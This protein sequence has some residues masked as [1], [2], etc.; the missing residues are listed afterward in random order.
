MYMYVLLELVYFLAY[1]HILYVTLLYCCYLI[2]NKLTPVYVAAQ[3][4]HIEALS[5]LISAGANVNA[6]TKVSCILTLSKITV[7]NV[8]ELSITTTHTSFNRLF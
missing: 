2:Q 7:Y 3:N 5:V 8:T 1:W 6:A 4:G